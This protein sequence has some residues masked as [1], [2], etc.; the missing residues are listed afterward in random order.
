MKFNYPNQSMRDFCSL[1]RHMM[2]MHKRYPYHPNL[3]LDSSL[4]GGAGT[5]EDQ[6][7]DGK[8]NTTVTAAVAETATATA[9]ADLDVEALARD[10]CCQ[11]LEEMASELELQQVGSG[12]GSGCGSGSGSG[13]SSSSGSG[14]G[15]G[16]VGMAVVVVA[17][18]VW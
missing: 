8:R 16:S 12:R 7:V 6:S 3:Y 13:S 11:A 9:V 10:Q 5:C 2:T 4:S 15:S 1:V 17:V 14:S 18:V